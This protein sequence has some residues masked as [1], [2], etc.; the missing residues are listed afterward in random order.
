[1][2]LLFGILYKNPKSQREK[3]NYSAIYAN[4]DSAWSGAAY[5]YLVALA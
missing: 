1:M 5:R 4:F 2:I 3:K